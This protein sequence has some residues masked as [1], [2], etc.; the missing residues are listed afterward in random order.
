MLL[1]IKKGVK[2]TRIEDYYITGCVR[3]THWKFKLEI[4]PL[5]K[6]LE[7]IWNVCNY[8]KLHNILMIM[9]IGR[10]Y[11]ENDGSI[12]GVKEYSS[13]TIYLGSIVCDLWR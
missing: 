4:C 2:I 13:P 10:F 7:S 6:L 11:L 3:I 8:N 12:E 5:Q 9:T 1:S